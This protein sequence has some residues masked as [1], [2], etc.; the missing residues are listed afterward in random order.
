M[1]GEQED[2]C[3]KIYE[4]MCLENCGG[5]TVEEKQRRHMEGDIVRNKPG[6]MLLEGVATCQQK[7]AFKEWWLTSNTY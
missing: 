3:K 5:K 1:R 6:D 2:T 4:K 7:G